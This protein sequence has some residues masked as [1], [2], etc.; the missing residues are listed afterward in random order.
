MVVDPTSINPTVRH[1]HDSSPHNSIPQ[2]VAII[3]T[4]STNAGPPLSQHAVLTIRSRVPYGD[5]AKKH[6]S[7]SSY[8]LCQVWS[9]CQVGDCDV[10]QHCAHHL[11][12]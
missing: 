10:H 1:T 4:G 8:P 2:V 9:T 7:G 6:L 11:Q 5:Q 12:V 3:T